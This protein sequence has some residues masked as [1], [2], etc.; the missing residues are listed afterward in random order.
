MKVCFVTF[1]A[2]SGVFGAER[3]LVGT[4]NGLR[5]QGVECCAIVNDETAAVSQ[6]LKAMNVPVR[7]VGFRLGISSPGKPKWHRFVRTAIN[8]V[9]SVKV[10]WIVR[11]W[12]ADVIYSNSLCVNTGAFASIWTRRPHVWHVHEFGQEDH[13][14]RFD[15]GARFVGP[16]LNSLSDACIMVSHAVATKFAPQ[17]S[18]AK[19]HV[20]YQS[21]DVEQGTDEAGPANGRFRCVIAG[22]LVEGKRQEDAIRAIAKL[23][24]EGVNVE[25]DIVGD[26]KGKYPERLRNLVQV[27]NMHD[28]VRFVGY[29]DNPFPFMRA[30]D[31][32]LVCS[33]AEAF[34]RV[35]VEAFLAGKPVIGA[36]SGGTA[37]LIEQ[38]GGLLYTPG[39]VADLAS[40]IR[41]LAGD[42]VK[43]KQIGE[44]ARAWATDRFTQDR[45]AVQ[46]VA[47]LQRLLKHKALSQSQPSADRGHQEVKPA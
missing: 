17:V 40:Q 2:G 18:D 3:W 46:T 31:A 29:R 19:S 35:T 5:A 21:V 37:E 25:L 6:Q 22:R 7:K 32:V 11:R 9:T 34:G 24:S 42:R 10:A 36:R 1:A 8:I 13:G 28:R 44:T 33:T 15:V 30:A 38:G 16:M 43:T 47:I 39:D 20:I 4:I 23:S 26:G 14:W 27:T 45:A 41:T 12:K